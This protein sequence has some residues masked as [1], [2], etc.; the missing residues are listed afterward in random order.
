M[1]DELK[2]AEIADA[3]EAE[4]PP[5]DLVESTLNRIRAEGEPEPG[6]VTWLDSLAA[7]VRHWFEGSNRRTAFAMATL[8]LVGIFLGRVV[9]PNLT[10]YHAQGELA[11]CRQNLEHLGRALESFKRQDGTYPRRLETLLDGYLKKIPDCPAA[12]HQTYRYRLDG[13]DF[14]VFCKGHHHA[15]AGQPK[16]YPQYSSTLGSSS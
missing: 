14:V 11:S 9:H 6:F 1:N 10:R 12:G 3:W 13:S 16:N 5:E 4:E 15:Q 8:L 7:R 2:V